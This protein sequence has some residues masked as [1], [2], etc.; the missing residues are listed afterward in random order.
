VA[1]ILLINNG[2]INSSG[3]ALNDPDGVADPLAHR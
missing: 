3:K 2:K 1:G